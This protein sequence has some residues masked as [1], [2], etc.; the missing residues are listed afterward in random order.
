LIAPLLARSFWKMKQFS[1]VYGIFSEKLSDFQGG[2]LMLAIAEAEE[3]LTVKQA[4]NLLH[5]NERTIRNH[6]NNARLPA[7]KL[8]AG[9]G[10]LIQ[11]EDLFAA[12]QTPSNL[13]P[14]TVRPGVIEAGSDPMQGDPTE[15]IIRRTHT[16]EGRARAIAALDS[17]LDD[18][19]DEQR[20]AWEH[21]QRTG[22]ESELQFRRWN[23]ET[24]ERQ[25]TPE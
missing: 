17:L 14:P 21:L 8:P 3:L 4:A 7:R 1:G 16:A 9:K 11:R 23:I 15:G 6:I 10:W 13:R 19:A 18:D 24:W 22:P 20:L 2:H 12:L 25:D 5:L